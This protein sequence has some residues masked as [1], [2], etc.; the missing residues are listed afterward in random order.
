MFCSSVKGCSDPIKISL[1][2]FAMSSG[3]GL[4]SVVLSAIVPATPSLP[5]PEFI[6]SITSGV[7]CF[8]SILL[9]KAIPLRVKSLSKYCNVAISSVI[10]APVLSFLFI[11][12]IAASTAFSPLF[13][14]AMFSTP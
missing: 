5:N 8:L 6:F 11:P 1:N 9:Y 10:S 13:C 14:K 2:F 4:P 3:I 12:F 7:N